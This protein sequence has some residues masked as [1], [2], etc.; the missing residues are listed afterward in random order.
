MFSSLKDHTNYYGNQRQFINC[1]EYKQTSAPPWDQASQTYNNSHLYSG[2]QN[3][4]SKLPH[5]FH[6][7]YNHFEHKN[8]EEYVPSNLV[9]PT[10]VIN[11][12]P[13]GAACCKHPNFVDHHWSSGNN[14]TLQY[15]SLSNESG[16][17]FLSDSTSRQ[18]THR[19]SRDIETSSLPC[20]SKCAR[21]V[22]PP[23]VNNN[24]SSNIDGTNNI[25]TNIITPKNCHSSE[26]NEDCKG[27]CR[28][29]TSQNISEYSSLDVFAEMQQT[30]NRE[31]VVRYAGHH[32]IDDGS[33]QTNWSSGYT[34]PDVWA[35]NGHSGLWLHPENSRSQNNTFASNVWPERSEIAKNVDIP[36]TIKFQ[37]LN[38]QKRS[39][40]GAYYQERESIRKTDYHENIQSKYYE[41]TRHRDKTR[42]KGSEEMPVDNSGGYEKFCSP[43]RK[44]LDTYVKAANDVDYQEIGQYEESP[45][46]RHQ[47]FRHKDIHS[48]YPKHISSFDPQEPHRPF[49]PEISN[50]ISS[51]VHSRGQEIGS[52]FPRRRWTESNSVVPHG[53][54]ST[55]IA[56][57]VNKPPEVYTTGIAQP[58]SRFSS[59]ITYTQSKISRSN[60]DLTYSQPYSN[61]YDHMMPPSSEMPCPTLHRTNPACNSVTVQNLQPIH[62]GDNSMVEPEVQ[63]LKP[64]V[65]YNYNSVNDLSDEYNLTC[66]PLNNKINPDTMSGK[67]VHNISNAY[68]S[69]KD[70]RH[71]SERAL[72]YHNYMLRNMSLNE[73]SIGYGPY[74]TTSTYNAGLSNFPNPAFI[75]RQ[76]IHIPSNEAI[77]R[78]MDCSNSG[79]YN[80][81]TNFKSMR[82]SNFPHQID[83]VGNRPVK[84]R[85]TKNK[86]SQN[87]QLGNSTDSQRR[88]CQNIGS[89]NHL[90][91]R[92]FLATWDEE[93]EDFSLPRLPDVVLSNSS[94]PVY[95]LD[96]SSTVNGL[97]TVSEEA[98]GNKIV[99]VYTNQLETNSVE[100]V[101]ILK[102]HLQGNHVDVSKSL[103]TEGKES[104]EF[105]DDDVNSKKYVKDQSSECTDG[106]KTNSAFVS[107]EL[108]EIVNPAPVIQNLR[109][110]SVTATHD[111]FDGTLKT[112]P[113][114]R[115]LPV[116]CD[117]KSKELDCI[118]MPKLETCDG[119]DDG[120]NLNILSLDNDVKSCSVRTLER[121]SSF[122]SPSCN[123]IPLVKLNTDISE[124]YP[125][126]LKDDLI[127][128]PECFEN[129][130]CLTVP[131]DQR[132]EKNSTVEL[133]LTGGELGNQAAQIN[134]MELPSEIKLSN[135][136]DL[137]ADA[138][139]K[140]VENKSLGSVHPESTVHIRYLSSESS[141]RMSPLN[142]FSSITET[143][144]SCET[145]H[146]SPASLGSQ[147]ICSI[148][149]NSTCNTKETT[150]PSDSYKAAESITREE[151][152]ADSELEMDKDV[153]IGQIQRNE[154]VSHV[155]APTETQSNEAV[156]NEDHSSTEINSLSLNHESK[157]SDTKS[158]TTTY[159]KN[160]L[161]EVSIKDSVK[162]S[163]EFSGVLPNDVECSLHNINSKTITKLSHEPSVTENVK[164]VSKN[165][166]VCQNT[167]SDLLQY[168]CDNRGSSGELN[169]HSN[170]K[171]INGDLDKESAESFTEIS[172]NISDKSDPKMIETKIVK[173]EK[174]TNEGSIKKD[175]LFDVS[176]EI[177]TERTEESIIDLSDVSRACKHPT[178]ITYTE[179]QNKN[180]YS[181]KSL[182]LSCS[183]N[184]AGENNDTSQKEGKTFSNL[185]TSP[186]LKDLPNNSPINCYL[187]NSTN[188]LNKEI[189]KLDIV[190]DS[191]TNICKITLNDKMEKLSFKSEDENQSTLIK[192][193]TYKACVKG[194]NEL[195]TV[196][197]KLSNRNLTDPKQI[198]SN[199]PQIASNNLM[200]DEVKE[201]KHTKFEASSPNKIVQI[202]SDFDVKDSNALE[203][204]HG[205]IVNKI[206]TEK[207]GEKMELSYTKSSSYGEIK[208]TDPV[209]HEIV[210]FTPENLL[211]TTKTSN[212]NCD[213]AQPSKPIFHEN[214]IDLKNS[215]IELKLK[216]SND[217]YANT[218]YKNIDSGTKLETEYL[219]NHFAFNKTGHQETGMDSS[220]K[221]MSHSL[222]SFEKMDSRDIQEAEKKD[223]SSSSVCKA[224]FNDICP[225]TGM[226]HK[227]YSDV[228]RCS[229]L[230][231]DHDNYKYMSDFPSDFQSSEP[232]DFAKKKKLC[233]TETDRC[234]DLKCF[235]SIK[236]TFQLFVEPDPPIIHHSNME[237]ISP[238]DVPP[239][240]M[241][242]PV[243]DEKVIDSK[244]SDSSSVNSKII[245]KYEGVKDSN[246]LNKND[247]LQNS[248]VGDNILPINETLISSCSVTNEQKDY[249]QIQKSEK[250]FRK[251]LIDKLSYSRKI[252]CRYKNLFK[253]SYQLKHKRQIAVSVNN[254]Q[255]THFTCNQQIRKRVNKIIRCQ[256][257]SKKEVKAMRK[258]KTKLKFSSNFLFG[259]NMN[260]SSVKV[261]SDCSSHY[262]KKFRKNRKMNQNNK[263]FATKFSDI[264]N[265]ILPVTQEGDISMPQ[266]E[267]ISDISP[268]I[269]NSVDMPDLDII[270]HNDKCVSAQYSAV[271][272]ENS[273]T[274]HHNEICHSSVVIKNTLTINDG[275]LSD[276]I[277]SKLSN[278]TSEKP[279][280]VVQSEV[281]E[282]VTNSTD[283]IP[284]SP[285]TLNDYEMPILEA[286]IVNQSS[287][288][289]SEPSANSL[290]ENSVGSSEID[291]EMPCLVEYTENI[292]LSP[293]EHLIHEQSDTEKFV[294]SGND[295]ISSSHLSTVEE[296]IPCSKNNLMPVQNV[297]ED[298]H[299]IF[300]GLESHNTQFP[301]VDECMIE[302]NVQI[303]PSTNICTSVD[304]YSRESENHLTSLADPTSII[305]MS[306]EH[307]IRRINL[308]KK[309][310]TVVTRPME[311]GAESDIQLG[312]DEFESDECYGLEEEN[313]KIC[314]SIT[315][316]ETSFDVNSQI[317]PIE[318]VLNWPYL[319]EEVCCET[320]NSD[321]ELTESYVESSSP[322]IN[323]SRVSCVAKEETTGFLCSE[324]N[325]SSDIKFPISNR[326]EE[327]PKDDM[328]TEIKCRLSWKK[329]FNLSKKEERD[330]KI[331]R[332]YT[333]KWPFY[334]QAVH[335]LKHLKSN[336]SHFIKKE[337]EEMFFKSCQSKEEDC[338]ELGD[339]I[340]DGLELGPAKIELRLASKP[341][342]GSSSVWEVVDDNEKLNIWSCK[343]EENNNYVM[344]SI[345]ASEKSSDSNSGSVPIVLVKR[346][347][348]TRRRNSNEFTSSTDLS[349]LHCERFSAE[350]KKGKRKIGTDSY[351]HA[352]SHYK[353]SSGVCNVIDKVTSDFCGVMVDKKSKNVS[354][355]GANSFQINQG[356]HGVLDMYAVKSKLDPNTRKI[357]R[358]SK[359][360]PRVII[361]RS[362]STT[363]YESFL[364]QT[365][366]RTV[367]WQ[368]VVVLERDSFLDNLAKN[369]CFD[370][371]IGYSKKLFKRSK[372]ELLSNR[373]S[374]SSV[375]SK[376]MHNQVLHNLSFQNQEKLKTEEGLCKYVV[377]E[378]NT[379]E[380]KIKFQRFKKDDLS[381]F[382]S[383]TSCDSRSTA[384]KSRKKNRSKM[385]VIQSK[386]SHSI[387]YEQSSSDYAPNLFHYDHSITENKIT[388]SN[389]VFHNDEAETLHK[390]IEVKNTEIDL[391][392][393]SVSPNNSMETLPMVTD[394]SIELNNLRTENILHD[395]CSD[396]EIKVCDETEDHCL[397]NYKK[398][399]LDKNSNFLEAN[400]L[401]AQVT[402]Q[403]KSGSLH[404][405]LTDP[406]EN[407]MA[408]PDNSSCVNSVLCEICNH[409]DSSNKNLHNHHH[410]PKCDF[411]FEFQ[412][413][414]IKFE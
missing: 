130:Q 113:E 174:V 390:I 337:S 183:E 272:L 332:V 329:I 312:I 180:H 317:L 151:C 397:A 369:K 387:F 295:S 401:D 288:G 165:E 70:S 395:Y 169:R 343:G 268:N 394:K 184:G 15:S 102:N 215:D 132:L 304:D 182:K 360:L 349:K 365:D 315:G 55:N 150:S 256:K 155:D 223:C 177:K 99:E 3:L 16:S 131:Y 388:G 198:V 145:T 195:F 235:K 116:N 228:D 185:S 41:S 327:L 199:I 211:M 32:F 380:T 218:S 69:N 366:S 262:Q 326:N 93:S 82:E 281:Q 292:S 238:I 405:K 409:Q 62:Y 18:N 356:R 240:K 57:G 38:N 103:N 96:C 270:V 338:L 138:Y 216:S 347:I 339:N 110:K 307:A 258:I 74:P 403:N 53:L 97:T 148:I 206:E 282:S 75:N 377:V 29:Y 9:R 260:K 175:V 6:Y 54:S 375:K 269:S 241:C 79:N 323:V 31:N 160:A 142:K 381:N 159:S 146:T 173:E 316:D 27:S 219:K 46:L 176:M 214:F 106:E 133:S 86:T 378:N 382:K 370:Q 249:T 88:K 208:M 147:N 162:K 346:L 33:A 341:S 76:K 361:K 23:T 271:I 319:E 265:N 243:T 85:K 311:G 310:D 47:D 91:V 296:R 308:S 189:E 118:C 81:Y 73:H 250:H 357:S 179:S 203:T 193:L 225:E 115:N 156:K 247:A 161:N 412:V 231:N 94:T 67:L 248:A 309:C 266:L 252:K 5:I 90:D 384:Y 220:E 300:I 278:I 371:S 368:P 320:R 340:I 367:H 107:K 350:P 108:Q 414:T 68:F 172:A 63:P 400:C 213:D 386:E 325:T 354:Q 167:I 237:C 44:K 232:N 42:K 13:N 1:E 187:H 239:T 212:H 163:N 197:K 344:S 306:Q 277:I 26:C 19:F 221:H 143:N 331:R 233:V 45:M 335:K 342:D 21:K 171:C 190:K 64:M 127:N 201:I 301:T 263:I 61:V 168:V 324:S 330:D 71:T 77:K 209:I 259:T 14:I 345:E 124:S 284:I 217:Y 28:F 95:I 192:N 204:Y 286:C 297:C 359:I 202:S 336:K 2:D 273:D 302:N 35:P 117:I 351:P 66:L 200:V 364:C 393:P 305:N 318:S 140:L 210:E 92:Q 411:T 112:A 196:E 402:N 334:S 279:M 120:I 254:F 244:D 65:S 294:N 149:I 83:D 398:K 404:E 111:R 373:E 285:S 406:D 291:P 283:D 164:S 34:Q 276:K 376:V 226:P 389:Y 49:V 89:N 104:H 109:E 413:S 358:E 374:T 100:T 396:S 119:F 224:L 135:L 51:A 188:L 261:V 98:N 264:D 348:L 322:D 59:H 289:L 137:A 157:I 230:E 87:E 391:L 234:S 181:T 170:V 30:V 24:Q 379:N 333:K 191:K 352:L 314:S 121:K 7:P 363:K 253:M 48:I 257:N 287:S 245:S 290:Y 50:N 10:A 251:L 194:M 392:N 362:D 242:V 299:R 58:P 222:E 355:T 293:S 126:Q 136:D 17:K 20:V 139:E 125:K 60:N 236:E 122:D 52:S 313:L 12:Q 22:F 246:I 37:D 105:I 154:A 36:Q 407:G 134:G 321:T 267:V 207:T 40:V 114:D 78:D 43:M 158:N 274:L 275:Y 166:N 303:V 144:N 25:V 141:R 205:E 186:D 410:C 298:G 328:V 255:K 72:H 353:N 385:K 178:E 280:T 39:L 153:N 227:K 372:G 408:C 84:K 399:G 4:H 80:D 152:V 229:S 128:P 11:C 8:N 101:S 56:Y 123:N 383:Q 129:N